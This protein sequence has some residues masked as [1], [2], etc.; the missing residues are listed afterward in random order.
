MGIFSW[1]RRGVGFPPDGRH[2]KALDGSS[3]VEF[4]N[5]LAEKNPENVFLPY[6]YKTAE[7][8]DAR[9]AK[10]QALFSRCLKPAMTFNDDGEVWICPE[11]ARELEKPENEELTELLLSMGKLGARLQKQ[12]RF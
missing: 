3:Q 9:S 2:E 10:I 6:L 4:V 5:S 7:E 11:L 12:G 1:L 8:N